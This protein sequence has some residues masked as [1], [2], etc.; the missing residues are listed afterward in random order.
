M[1]IS[2]IGAG[3]VGLVTGVGLAS[4]GHRVIC[5]D[6]DDE[7]VRK[8]NQGKCPIYEKGLPELLT[9]VLSNKRFSATTDLNSAILDST[10]TF[11][12]VGTPLTDE[13]NIDLSFVKAASH[14]IGSALASKEDYHVIVIRSTV[15]PGTCHDVVLPLIEKSSGKARG[16]FGLCMNPEFFREGEAVKD[17]THPDRIIIGELDKKSG[18]CLAEVYNFSSAPILRTSLQTAELIKYTNN[19]LLSTLISFSNEIAKICELT[20][21]DVVQVLKGVHFDKRL[22]PLVNGKRVNPEILTYLMAG[23][24][25]GGS[26]LPKD[27]KALISFCREKIGYG[28]ELLSSVLKVNEE[29]PIH[30]VDMVEKELGNLVNRKVAVLGLAFKPETDDVRNSPAISII[31]ELAQRGAFISAYDPRAMKNAKKALPNLNLKFCNSIREVVREA[32]ACILV[33]K[34]DEFKEITPELLEEEMKN[35][36]FVDGRRFL[37]KKNLSEKIKYIGIGL[38]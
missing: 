5:V 27:I 23:C 11:V 4:Q 24:G 16:E 32:E 19:A 2:V 13:G 18:D 22:N 37:G 29:Q 17:F 26:C 7:K 14:Q 9:T 12:C 3:H 35:P 6:I 25:F 10:L 31:R 30:L 38:G 8:I 15:V 28:P 20:G 1:N 33:T 36:L 21:C 34:W